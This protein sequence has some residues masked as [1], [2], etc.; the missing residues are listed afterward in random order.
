VIFIRAGKIPFGRLVWL[1]P[2]VKLPKLIRFDEED[3]HWYD[4]LPRLILKNRSDE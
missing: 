1:V 4:K 2:Q 3:K